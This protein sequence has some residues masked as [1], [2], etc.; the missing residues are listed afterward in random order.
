MISNHKLFVPSIGLISALACPISSGAT[1]F[2]DNFDSGSIDAAVWD[3]GS[4]SESGSGTFETVADGTLGIVTP[5]SVAGVR[6]STRVTALTTVARGNDWT[7]SVTMNL[8]ALAELSSDFAAGDG[9]ALTVQV[10]NGIQSGDRL[11]VNFAAINFGTP[12]FAVRSADRLEGTGNINEPIIP[13]SGSAAS[14]ATIILTYNG[15]TQTTS[16]AYQVNGGPLTRFGF[17]SDLSG[18]T[19]G[20]GDDFV[21]AIEALAGNFAGS[22]APL[23]GSMNFSAG[24][25]AFDSITLEDTYTALP[26]IPEP[27]T[28]LLAGLAALAFCSRRKR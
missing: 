27:T 5:G 23:D 9:V 3:I 1:L 7:L 18:W 25:A 16:S 13:I 15:T 20:A 10:K 26:A 2:S 11:E 19:S 28:S 24:E 14:T 12:G 17:D 6:P 8:A 22:E 4:L 21:F